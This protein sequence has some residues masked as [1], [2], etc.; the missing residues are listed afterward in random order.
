VAPAQT[1]PPEIFWFIPGAGDDR[2]LGAATRPNS[3]AYLASIAQVADTLGF[4]RELLPTAGLS[5]DTIVIGS[6]VLSLTRRL[7]V[8]VAMRP[9]FYGSQ[10]HHRPLNLLSKHPT[11][12][13]GGADV[14]SQSVQAWK[15]TLTGMSCRPGASSPPTRIGRWTMKG[16]E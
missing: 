5:E 11:H 10:Y 1:P 8:L 3:F 12:R 2:H 15:R 16:R 7:R 14:G 6:A 4:D 9:E 13:G